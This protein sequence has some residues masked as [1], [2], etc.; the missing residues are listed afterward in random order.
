MEYKGCDEGKSATR[1][2]ADASQTRDC[3]D[4][5]LKCHRVP[6][7]GTSL[8]AKRGELEAVVGAA[9]NVLCE[10]VRARRAWCIGGRSTTKTMSLLLAQKSCYESNAMLLKCTKVCTRGCHVAS[11]LS[12]MFVGVPSV[13]LAV[14][15]QDCAQTSCDR[16]LRAATCSLG[17]RA[18]SWSGGMAIQGKQRP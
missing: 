12:D 1:P 16:F 7:H 18:P 4:Q 15:R 6:P 17:S 13:V 8:K 2:M 14:A 10:I 11:S 9:A 5:T 3:G